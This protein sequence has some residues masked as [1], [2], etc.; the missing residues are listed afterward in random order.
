MISKSDLPIRI[1]FTEIEF[2]ETIHGE[3]K[4]EN[5]IIEGTEY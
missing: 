3:K 1:N 5:K 2:P 4:Q